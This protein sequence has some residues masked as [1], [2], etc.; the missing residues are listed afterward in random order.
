[1]VGIHTLEQYLTFLHPT[2]ALTV[3][4]AVTAVL[5]P[6]TSCISFPSESED[7]AKQLEQVSSSLGVSSTPTNGRLSCSTSSPA[8]RERVAKSPLPDTSDG[9]TATCDSVTFSI[10]SNCTDE[11]PG[12]ALEKGFHAQQAWVWWYE[13][14]QSYDVGLARVTEAST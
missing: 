10:L 12:V 2:Q 3:V 5:L 14:N 7:H 4:V 8:G 1:M 11:Y 9:F 6:R 13:E